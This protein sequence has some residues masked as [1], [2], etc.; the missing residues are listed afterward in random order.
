MPLITDPDSLNDGV[1]VV[2]STTNKTIQLVATGNIENK[3]ADGGVTLQALYSWLK[4]EWKTNPTYIKFPFPMEA[5][6]PEQFEFINGWLPFNDTTRKLMRTAGWAEK[7]AAGAVQKKYIGVLSLGSLGAT[8]QPYYQIGNAAFV[9]FTYQGPINEAVQIFGDAS[10]GNFDYSTTSF[11][12]FCREQGKLY[13]TSDNSAIGASTLTYI[14]YR[15][16][17]SNSTDL[18]ISASDSLIVTGSPYSSIFVEYFNTNQNIDVDADGTAEPYRFIISG[19]GVPNA[20]TQQI[21]EKIQYLLR[22]GGDIDNGAGIVT[23]KV[24][25]GLLSFVG[26][27]LVGANGVFI[28]GLNSN[29]LNSV[30]FYDYTGMLHRYPFVSAGTINFGSF[31]GSGDFRYWMFFTTNPT[32]NYGTSSG[33][34]VQDKDSIPISGTY[35]GASVPFSFAYD[36]NTQGGRTAGANAPVTL[37]GIGLTGGQFATVESTITRSAGLSILL[38]PAQERNYTNP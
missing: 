5:I 2:I 3:G 29:Y 14:V 31:A 24:A 13:A 32:G 11:K 33:L 9:N 36:S 34:I 37:V 25:S 38:A 16:P 20:T 18:K 19:A 22:S 8:D 1:E 23:G 35:V 17:L 15:F 28:S 10:N 26:D 4:E 7:S 6:T 21:Y 30:D 12:L 27:T